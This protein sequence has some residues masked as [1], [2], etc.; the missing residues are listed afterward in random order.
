MPQAVCL[1]NWSIA[2]STFIATVVPKGDW[3]L[4]RYLRQLDSW[5]K[6]NAIG[7]TFSISDLAR[8]SDRGQRSR[9]TIQATLG[10]A[11]LGLRRQCRQSAGLADATKTTLVAGARSSQCGRNRRPSAQQALIAA[12]VS[13]TKLQRIECGVAASTGLK[14]R[15]PAIRQRARSALAAVN[16]DLLTQHDSMVVLTCSTMTEAS[17][18]R[19]LAQAIPKLVNIWPDLRFWIIGDGPLREELHRYFKKP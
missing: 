7:L 18:I 9:T 15:E 16:R 17:G 2:K 12:G 14:G 10:T 19:T 4:S 3:S 8:R 11:S 13:P 1:I 6:Q 5:L